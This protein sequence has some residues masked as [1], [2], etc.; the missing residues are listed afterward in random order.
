MV[1][2]KGNK[3]PKTS[4][5]K[6]AA[7]MLVTCAAGKKRPNDENDLDNT[8]RHPRKTACRHAANSRMSEENEIGCEQQTSADNMMQKFAELQG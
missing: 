1:S 3:A 6:P 2:S 5:G 4:G 8:S 7:R